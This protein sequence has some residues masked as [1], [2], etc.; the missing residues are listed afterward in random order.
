MS[1]TQKILL[2]V[3]VLAIVGVSVLLRVYRHAIDPVVII[4][5]SLIV[6]GSLLAI[7]VYAIYRSDRRDR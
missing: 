2:A 1:R 6:G 3:Y 5:F 4:L 7:L